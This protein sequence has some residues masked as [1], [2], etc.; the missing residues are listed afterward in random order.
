MGSVVVASPSQAAHAFEGSSMRDVLGATGESHFDSHSSYADEYTGNRSGQGDRPPAGSVSVS[1]PQRWDNADHITPHRL[2]VSQR[3]VF[4]GSAAE[5]FLGSGDSAAHE[6]I[7]KDSYHQVE[8]QAP[9]QHVVRIACLP[10]LP[11]VHLTLALLARHSMA[12]CFEATALQASSTQNRM[13]NGL[14]ARIRQRSTPSK[15]CTSKKR[16][17]TGG[18]WAAE[19]M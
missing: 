6:S 2:L 13:K 11:S 15:L 8:G 17:V 19:S 10:L 9:V 7:Y 5:A 1:G 12:L 3:T 4:G 18:G 14:R 16:S